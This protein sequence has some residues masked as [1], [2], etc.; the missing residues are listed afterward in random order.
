MVF[1]VTADLANVH[2]DLFRRA[3]HLLDEIERYVIPWDPDA[4]LRLLTEFIS[5]SALNDSGSLSEP[6]ASQLL[7]RAVDLAIIAATE[8]TPSEQQERS[9]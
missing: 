6:R 9:H 1:N 5:H 7:V 8:P 2:A 3:N 4:A